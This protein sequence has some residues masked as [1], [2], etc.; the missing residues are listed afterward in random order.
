MI[1]LKNQ[2]RLPFQIVVRSNKKNHS[3]VYRSDY[4]IIKRLKI[5]TRYFKKIKREQ[6]PLELPPSI[7]P[8]GRESSLELSRETEP[9]ER[10][11]LIPA[12]KNPLEGKDFAIKIT[13]FFRLT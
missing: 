12:S 5:Y 2:T 11:G 6:I 9:L 4:K 10:K 7:R 8:V 1:Y 13:L 3:T